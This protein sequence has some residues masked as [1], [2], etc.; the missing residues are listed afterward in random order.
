[1][2]TTFKLSPTTEQKSCIISDKD[3]CEMHT[4][5]V[6]A[7]DEVLIPMILLQ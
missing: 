4:I 6:K 1:M 5:T 3:T 7:R 2:K